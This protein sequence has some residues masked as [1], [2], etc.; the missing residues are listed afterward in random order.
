MS[1]TNIN[2]KNLKKVPEPIG[3][4]G[5]FR[6]EIFHIPGNHVINKPDGILK[7]DKWTLCEI[8]KNGDPIQIMMESDRLKYLDACKMLV[9]LY[10]TKT[11][12]K[13]LDKKA[14]SPLN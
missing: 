2:L 10:I 7:P 11:W 1:K 13:I 3:D 5:L 14:V 9:E 6:F 12:E 8:D 4:T